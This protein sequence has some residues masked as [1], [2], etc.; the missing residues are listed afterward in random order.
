M[1][2]V[3]HLVL[4]V[5]INPIILLTCLATGFCVGLAMFAVEVVDCYRFLWRNMGPGCMKCRKEPTDG[6]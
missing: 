6:Q 4:W 5:L 3:L 2:R 1:S